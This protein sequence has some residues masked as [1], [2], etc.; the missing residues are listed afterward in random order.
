MRHTVSSGCLLSVLCWPYVASHLRS[1][2]SSLSPASAD[3]SDQDL[4]GGSVPSAPHAP[5]ESVDPAHVLTQDWV[6]R[7]L[8]AVTSLLCTLHQVTKICLHSNLLMQDPYQL[9]C[10]CRRMDSEIHR[11]TALISGVPN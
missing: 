5:D 6:G 7:V 2:Q 8:E 11:D 1:S 4:A 3:Q 10:N 9:H